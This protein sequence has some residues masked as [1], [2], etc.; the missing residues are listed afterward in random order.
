MM[1]LGVLGSAR[2]APPS[3][4]W[5]PSGFTPVTSDAY[6]GT[7]TP[8][9][10]ALGGTPQAV[11]T[12]VGDGPVSVA[13]GLLTL[14]AWSKWSTG[15][16]LTRPV[17]VGI[18]GITP[19]GLPGQSLIVAPGFPITYGN[20]HTGLTIFTSGGPHLRSHNANTDTVISDTVGD[21][22]GLLYDPAGGTLAIY[23][24]GTLLVTM[25]PSAGIPD[26][27]SGSAVT[28]NA[29]A[30]YAWTVDSFILAVG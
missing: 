18:A 23:R 27:T 16:D 3:G 25:T 17:Y 29:A 21:H 10:A 7:V 22:V 30:A 8:T 6:T 19:P 4:L 24:E 14:P 15:A 9:D 5:I 1:P 20:V 12:S 2:V 13:G 26:V 28:I 11:S